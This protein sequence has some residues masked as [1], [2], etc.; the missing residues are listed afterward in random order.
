VKTSKEWLMK[1]KHSS[2]AIQI[3]SPSTAMHCL[4]RG[5]NVKALHNPIVE[6]NI[7]LEYLAKTL[8]GNIPLVSTNRLFKS[9]SR[10]I[11]ECCRIGRVMLVEIDKI[12]VVLDFYI[13]VIL[14][15]D[16]LICCPLDKLFQE[17]LPMGALMR[18]LGKLLPPCLSFTQKSQ[19][20]SIIPTIIWSRR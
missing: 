20:Q 8:L 4:L 2:K 9:L 1:V 19:W 14:E 5:T 11:F 6:M 15:F 18:N 7:M 13:F 16:L 10:L 3:L 12:K 17:N